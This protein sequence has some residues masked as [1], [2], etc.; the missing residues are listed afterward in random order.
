M[1]N[2]GKITHRATTESQLSWTWPRRAYIAGVIATGSVVV[3][4]SAHRMGSQP[5]PP[6]W[7]ILA[8]LTLGTGWATV[9][10]PG[11]PVSVSLSDTF[12]MA[13]ALLF[14]PAAGALLS[15]ADG[16]VMSSRLPR[17]MRTAPRILFNVA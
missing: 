5:V 17:E 13:A 9:R 12:I 16:L 14:G 1:G 7:L 2:A 10:M 6:T 11:A 15:G 8:L 4:L 3:A